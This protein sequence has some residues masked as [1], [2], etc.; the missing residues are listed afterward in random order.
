MSPVQASKWV[1]ICAIGT[2]AV[3]VAFNLGRLTN[4]KLKIEGCEVLNYSTPF[5]GTL[6]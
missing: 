6:P 4:G 2:F 3:L 1:V 5:K